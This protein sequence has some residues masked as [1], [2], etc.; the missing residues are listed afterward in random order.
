M[1]DIY[2][3]KSNYNFKGKVLTG[4]RYFQDDTLLEIEQHEE[5][6]DDLQGYWKF[7]DGK[8]DFND[9]YPS[10]TG[11]MVD[12]K[13]S[14]FID[15]EYIEREK[16]YFDVTGDIIVTH[17]IYAY[18][19]NLSVAEIRATGV[20]IYRDYSNV[21]GARKVKQLQVLTA[22][23]ED[24]ARH[25]NFKNFMDNNAEHIEDYI[26]YYAYKRARK[27]PILRLLARNSCL[28]SHQQIL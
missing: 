24:N 19:G 28:I 26:K 21:I 12:V 9:L 7:N 17:T 3:Q 14:A 20:I 2:A 1:Y 27:T 5:I 22:F 25:V 6:T 23:D 10:I 11:Y 15:G 4:Y 18:N 8:L 16:L 13:T